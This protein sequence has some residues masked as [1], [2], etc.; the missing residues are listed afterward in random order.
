MSD[1]E[2]IRPEIL[3]VIKTA[4]AVFVAQKLL[5]EKAQAAPEKSW[6]ARGREIVQASHNLVQ[7]GH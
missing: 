2:P 4:A 1:G 7:R 5:S 3:T 6:S